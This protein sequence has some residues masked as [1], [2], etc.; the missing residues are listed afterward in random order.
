MAGLT[1]AGTERKQAARGGIIAKSGT[2][3]DA[4]DDRPLVLPFP[5]PGVP[6]RV[7]M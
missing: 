3:A 1:V 2:S 4:A 5:K 7:V 6:W